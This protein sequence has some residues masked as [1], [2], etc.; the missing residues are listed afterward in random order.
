MLRIRTAL[1]AGAALCAFVWAAAS[2][3]GAP[4]GPA[5]ATPTASL[6]AGFSPER[7]G[8]RATISFGVRVQAPPGELPPALA[9]M[10]LLYPENLGIATSGL[11]FQTCDP[12]RLQTK[13]LAACPADSLMGRGSAVVEVPIGPETVREN[14]DLTLISGPVQNGHLGLLFFASGTPPISAALVFPGLVLPTP[15]PFGGSLN[16]SMP[17]VPSVPEGADVSIVSLH[18]T[19]GP[20]HITYYERRHGRLVAYTPEGI[21]LPRSCPRGGF[22]F[23]V[24]LSFQDGTSTSA[25]S[26]VRCPRH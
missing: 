3:T 5:S 12:T 9:G 8:G 23:S 15:A 11:G 16:I 18:T 17:R 6:T 1:A 26:T 22:P 14:T 21:L 7:L 19:L 24:R 13:G 10:E 4:T 20:R 2:A 25:A